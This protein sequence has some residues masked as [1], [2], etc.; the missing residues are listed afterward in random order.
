METAAAGWCTYSRAWIDVEHVYQLNVTE[1]E[2]N[3][4]GEMLDVCDR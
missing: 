2:K 4:L 1:A 3:A